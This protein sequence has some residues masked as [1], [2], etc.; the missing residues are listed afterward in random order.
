[1][2]HIERNRE[3]EGDDDGDNSGIAGKTDDSGD[4]GGVDG[5]EEEED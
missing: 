3:E 4:N 1:M 5:D 2:G